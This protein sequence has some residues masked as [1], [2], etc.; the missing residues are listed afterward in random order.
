MTQPSQLRCTALACLLTAVPDT[1]AQDTTKDFAKG[2]FRVA[3]GAMG[4]FVGRHVAE[5]RANGSRS[6]ANTWLSP[7]VIPQVQPSAHSYGLMLA[8]NRSGN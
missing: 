2:V 1:F 6:P 8:W 7:E 5:R 4:W 3:G